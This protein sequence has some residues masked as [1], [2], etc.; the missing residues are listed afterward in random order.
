M[1][2]LDDEEPMVS[3]MTRLLERRGYRVSG[4]TCANSALA[5]VA[6][7]PDS[8]DVIVSDHNMPGATGV[9]VARQ[10]A[11]FWPNLK[12]IITSGYVDERLV[13]AAGEVGV[14]HVI[15][16]PDSIQGLGEAIDTVIRDTMEPEAAPLARRAAT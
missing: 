16:K 4:F 10:V 8:F 14:R 13:T 1:L 6:V 11:A 12:V 2:Y 9:D 3:L 5:A 7:A 15:Y